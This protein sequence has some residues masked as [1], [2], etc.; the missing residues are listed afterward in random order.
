[1]SICGGL[2]Y[3]HRMSS[4]Y[5]LYE[6]NKISSRFAPEAGVP[7]GV[8]PHYNINPAQTVVVIVNRGDV[9]KIE[10]MIWG[11]I[12]AGAKNNNSIFRY[13]TH[14]ARSEDVF[15]K[16]T[17]SRA[18]R[19]RRCLIPANGFYEWKNLET[20][21]TP[22]YIQLADQS[23]FSFA[24]LYGEWTDTDGVVW[25][26]CSIIT[27]NSDTDDNAIPSR[28]PVIVRPE[29]EKSWLDPTISD[30]STIYGIMKPLKPEQLKI[31]RISDDIKSSKIDSPYL[32][33]RVVKTN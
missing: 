17:W 2:Q 14:N 21:K 19:E 26:M 1:M 32:I 20:G 16:P 15:N 23:M 7:K 33:E 6:T 22:Y 28:L 9:K 11:F 24:G 13:K 12:P 8:K 25:G 27:T 18:I 4:Q 30:M 3:T 10:K 31:Y 29:D 5:V